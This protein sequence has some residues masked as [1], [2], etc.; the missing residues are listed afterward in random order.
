MAQG[1]GKDV[2]RLDEALAKIEALLK[3][4]VGM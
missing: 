1:G 4:Q 2:G 3:T